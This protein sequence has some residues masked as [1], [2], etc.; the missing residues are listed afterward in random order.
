M[1]R[2]H[3]AE[4][5]QQAAREAPGRPRAALVRGGAAGQRG[6]VQHVDHAQGVGRLAGQLSLPPPHTVILRSR[7]EVI[8][9]GNESH[10]I[11][12]INHY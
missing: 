4:G 12:H 8:P 3:Q 6:R 7:L 5:P 2:T 11:S 1:R 9:T 10:C